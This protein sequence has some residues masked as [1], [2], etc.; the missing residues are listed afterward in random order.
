VIDVVTVL[1][2]VV[3]VLVIVVLR[4]LIESWLVEA[5]VDHSSVVVV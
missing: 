1:L 4:C 2:V 3:V 5:S